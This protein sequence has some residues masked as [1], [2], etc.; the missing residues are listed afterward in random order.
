MMVL[1]TG[2]REWRDRVEIKV[3][4]GGWKRERDGGR[5]RGERQKLHVCCIFFKWT[6]MT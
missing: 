5:G 3:G 2:R 1:E 4:V 6:K